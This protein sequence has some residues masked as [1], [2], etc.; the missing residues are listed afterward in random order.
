MSKE[1]YYIQPKIFKESLRKYYDS[2]NLTDDLAENIKKIAYGLSY[3]SSFINYTYKD[4]MIGDALIKMYSALKHKKYKFETGSNPFSYFTTIAYHAFINRIK[5]EK[6]HHEAI[7]NYKEKVY[8][9]YMADPNNTHGHIY[10]K[11]VDD[12]SDD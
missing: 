9:E 5:K 7:C 2:D 4:D 3:N 10:V 12:D 6:K 1:Q 11:P 8:E